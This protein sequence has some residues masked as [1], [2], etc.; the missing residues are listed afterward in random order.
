MAATISRSRLAALV[1]TRCQ[2]FQT[3]YNPTSARTGAKYL[4]ARL[5]GPSMV[6]YYPP[7]ANI[8]QLV[9]DHK[10]AQLVDFEE[11][12][13]LQDVEDKKRRGKGAPPKAK[14]KGPSETLLL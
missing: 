4:R 2:I 6:K 11:A 14:D 13:R 8:A 10:A 12:Q 7:V 1:K 3:A 9:K 5:R